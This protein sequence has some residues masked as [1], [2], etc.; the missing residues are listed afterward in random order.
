[1]VGTVAA[2]WLSG[3]NSGEAARL[4]CFLTPW[5]LVLAAHIFRSEKRSDG[6]VNSAKIWKTLLFMQ[7]IVCALTAARVSGF[8]FSATLP[9]VF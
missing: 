6:L 3:R 7:I 1:L 5:L 8:T 4:W 2:L 9:P